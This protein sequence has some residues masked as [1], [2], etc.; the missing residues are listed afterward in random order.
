MFWGSDLSRLS[1]SYSECVE[2]FTTELPWLRGED[3]KMVMGLGLRR[4][5]GW[6]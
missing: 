2:L 5:L 6:T 3:L 4:W 1:S